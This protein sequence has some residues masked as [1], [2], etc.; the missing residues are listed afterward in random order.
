[1]TVI[2]FLQ[3][4]E[5]IRHEIDLTRFVMN[6]I[7]V[8]YETLIYFIGKFQECNLLLLKRN[9]TCE[10]KN[11]PNKNSILKIKFHKTWL[12]ARIQV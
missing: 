10:I 5:V 6:A 2:V 9:N 7:M 4:R 8:N 3:F 12:K 11:K 1:M